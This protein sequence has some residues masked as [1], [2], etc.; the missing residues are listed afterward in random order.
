MTYNEFLATDIWRKTAE[1]V[2]RK[3]GGQCEHCYTAEGP[4]QAHHL[5][6]RAPN[7]RDAPRSIPRG[8][9]PSFKWLVCLC[10]D[11]HHLLH[12]LLFVDRFWAT[13]QLFQS[14]VANLHAECCQTVENTFQS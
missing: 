3:A 4:F 14:H 9:L 12:R 7:R 11:C 13:R 8:W 1:S 10:E 2:Y 5:T 6:Y